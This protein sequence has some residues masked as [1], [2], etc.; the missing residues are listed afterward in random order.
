MDGPTPGSMVSSSTV[1][2]LRFSL[3][4]SSFLALD[5][6]GAFAAFFGCASSLGGVVGADRRAVGPGWLVDQ[7][8]RPGQPPASRVRWA[9]RQ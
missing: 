2:V 7:L 9:I 5:A 6:F 4:L 1:A 8:G 3:P